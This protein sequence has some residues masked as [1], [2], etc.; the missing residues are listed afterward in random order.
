MANSKSKDSQKPRWIRL[1]LSII[2]AAYLGERFTYKGNDFDLE[3]TIV[4]PSDFHRRIASPSTRYELLLNSLDPQFKYLARSEV[5]RVR[6]GW[7]KQ[8][9][10]GYNGMK[11]RR[12]K[13][14]NDVILLP[15][16]S[17]KPSVGIDTSFIQPMTTV[18]AFCFLPDPKGAY[19]YLEKHLNLPKTHN[20][21]EFKWVKLNQNFKAKV[22][23]KFELFLS[24]CCEGILVINTDALVSPIG[25]VENIFF[26]LIEGCFSGYENDPIQAKLRPA[27]RKKFFKLASD[28]QIHCDADFR[29]L[30]PNKVVRYSVQILAKRGKYFEKFVP[31][32]AELK[33]HESESIQ[34]AD[35]IVGAIRTKIQNKEPLHPLK[36]LPFDGCK[37]KSCKGRFAKAYYWFP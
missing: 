17:D 10:N 25:K 33:S 29:P 2:R 32:F 35:I 9:L 13:V 16:L 4:K 18:L 20:H 36:S 21:R 24:I 37:I 14:E 27:L 5:Y 28:V 11:I 26:N 8:G 15:I 12:V 30:T 6:R 1:F 23:K 31:L 3:P 19:A 7:V 22:F 34:V